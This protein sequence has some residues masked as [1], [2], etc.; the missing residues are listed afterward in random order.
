MYLRNR[1]RKY[2]VSNKRAI[3]RVASM[4][5]HCVSRSLSLLLHNRSGN[6]EGSLVE[7]QWRLYLTSASAKHDS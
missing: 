2:D 4:L 7:P 3:V 6:G 1:G 5:P